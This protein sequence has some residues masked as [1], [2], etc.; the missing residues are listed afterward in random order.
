M[1]A[2]L[3]AGGVQTAKCKRKEPTEKMTA[4][5]ERPKMGMTKYGGC[6]FIPD[7]AM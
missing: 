6:I 4:D 5:S 2:F 1:F 3:P 7:T